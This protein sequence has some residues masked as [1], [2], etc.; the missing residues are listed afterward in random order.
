MKKGRAGGRHLRDF[1]AIEL[2]FQ[3]ASTCSQK[4][5]LALADKGLGYAAPPVDL[6]RENGWPRTT[7][8]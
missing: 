2:Y 3:K 1:T 4:V 6:L 8:R 5:R 7:W